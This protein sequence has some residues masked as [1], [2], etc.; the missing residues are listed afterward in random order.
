MNNQNYSP[1][2]KTPYTGSNVVQVKSFNNN[3]SVNSN[4]Y[5]PNY[6]KIGYPHSK[7]KELITNALLYK[8]SNPNITSP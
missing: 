1:A 2:Y 7:P 6:T 8:T 3:L 5:T 4:S